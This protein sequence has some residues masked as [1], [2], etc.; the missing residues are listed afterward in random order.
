MN[1]RVMDGVTTY[2][3]TNQNNL[4]IMKLLFWNVDQANREENFPETKWDR[5]TGEVKRL[6]ADNNADIVG[7]VELRNLATSNETAGQFLTHFKQYDSIVRRYC[8]YKDAFYM[9]LMFKPE[10]YFAGDVRIHNYEHTP[11]NDK[12]VMFVDLQDK[13]TFK[14]FTIGITHFGIQEEIKTNASRILRN[15]ILSQKYPCAVY[16][17]FNFFDDLQGIQQ[18]SYMLEKLHDLAHPLGFV[19]DPEG[20]MGTTTG[21]FMGFPHD[22]HKQS[23][24]KMSRLDHVFATADAFTSDVAISPCLNDYDFDNSAYATYT[25]P[26]DHLA[27]QIVCHCN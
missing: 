19:N 24:Y 14:W 20:P 21:T 13:A 7:L 18:R 12:M 2:H 5:R 11:A 8:H 22:D 17:D 9:A 3:Y 10:K 1:R 27:I 25:Y 26:S 16:G 23:F 15:L 6:I 4:A